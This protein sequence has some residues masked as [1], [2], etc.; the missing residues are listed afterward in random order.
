MYYPFELFL[1][2]ISNEYPLCSI[3]FLENYGHM[4][5]PGYFVVKH[6]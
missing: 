4:V 3:Y 1:H 5:K 6:A 2:N